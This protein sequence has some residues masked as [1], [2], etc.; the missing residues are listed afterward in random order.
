MADILI[1]GSADHPIGS[2]IWCAMA[3]A[4]IERLRGRVSELLQTTNR[5]QER[6]R[7]AEARQHPFDWHYKYLMRE[8]RTR[9]GVIDPEDGS[10]TWPKAG[11]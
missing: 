2:P 3:V 7:K 5:Y 10:V 11:R 9:G 8:I 6:Y 4:E 1:H